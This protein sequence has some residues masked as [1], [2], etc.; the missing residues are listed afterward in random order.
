MAELAVE[1]RLG[2]LRFV[3]DCNL[4]A[5]YQQLQKQQQAA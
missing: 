5:M 2:L 1:N 3:Q 4:K